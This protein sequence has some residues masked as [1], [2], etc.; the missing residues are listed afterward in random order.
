MQ[1]VPDRETPW[2]RGGLFF[3][4]IACGR[5]CRGEPGAIFFTP[6]EAEK[7]CELL[8]V[9]ADEFKRRFVT[10][11]WGKP[12][13]IERPNGDCIFYRPDDAKCS[14]YRAR[15]KQCSLFP[16]WPSLMESKKTW[17]AYAVS[18]PGMNSGRFY[19][20]EEIEKLLKES[21]FSDL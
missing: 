14:V 3:S 13:F 18:C 12:S 16:F 20:G 5:C 10:L 2:W 21:P 9:G 4:C 6:A 1:Y 11:R 15:P 8:N 17:D 19:S 7:V